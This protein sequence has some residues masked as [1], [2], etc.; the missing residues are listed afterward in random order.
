M[1]FKLKEKVLVD[2]TKQHDK[3]NKTTDIM[4]KEMSAIKNSKDEKW[5]ELEET[6]RQLDYYKKI[7]T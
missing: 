7:Y 4:I 5:K 6:N 2:L 3:L 1:E